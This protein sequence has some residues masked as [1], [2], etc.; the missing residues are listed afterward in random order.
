M[1][2]RIF[3]VNNG[4]DRL[5]KA[6]TVCTYIRQHATSLFHVLADE[7]YEKH[8]GSRL[9]SSLLFSLT[10]SRTFKNFQ[11]GMVSRLN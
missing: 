7:M 3:I 1:A 11:D 10:L 2:S 9:S 8:A 4:T 6:R 5:T